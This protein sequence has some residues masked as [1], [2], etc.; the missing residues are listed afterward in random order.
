MEWIIGRPPG[1]TVAAL[2]SEGEVGSARL[3]MSAIN[4]GEVLLLSS[5]K[6]Q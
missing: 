2:L 4:V 5:K 6:P 1:E 3:L